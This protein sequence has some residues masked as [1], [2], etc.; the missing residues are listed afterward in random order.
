MMHLTIEIHIFIYAI[1]LSITETLHLNIQSLIKVIDHQKVG[2]YPFLSELPS[3]NSLKTVPRITSYIKQIGKVCMQD[4]I[5][6]IIILFSS[7]KFTRLVGI[8]I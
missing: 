4:N 8:Y 2:T 1:E 7:G 3:E 5:S 6:R